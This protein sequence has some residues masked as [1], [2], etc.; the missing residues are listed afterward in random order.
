MPIEA[1]KSYLNENNVKYVSVSHSP[2]FTAPQI[3]QSAHI[4][5]KELA[6]TVIV[7]L[8]GSLAMVVLPSNLHVDFE[9]LKDATNVSV[10]EL[11]SEH[12]FNDKFPDC[13]VGA[14]PPFGNLYNMQVYVAKSLSADEEIAFNAGNH[15]ELIKMAYGDFENL[16]SPIT[17]EYC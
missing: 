10:A 8:D 9:A 16:V 1:L 4:P 15:S 3:A 12:E 11:A 13:E 17:L 5:G 14:M 6:K 2:A 7:K